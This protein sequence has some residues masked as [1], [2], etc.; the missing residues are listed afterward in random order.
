[1]AKGD[2]GDPGHGRQHDAAVDGHRPNLKGG[3]EMF[4]QWIQKTL[5]LCLKFLYLFNVFLKR[6]PT[7]KLRSS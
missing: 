5:Y 6:E 7:R 1:L 4:W 3:L 2:I